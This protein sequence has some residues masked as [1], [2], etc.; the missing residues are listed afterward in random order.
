MQ[1]SSRVSSATKAYED[2]EWQRVADAIAARC[3][4]PRAKRTELHVAGS[5]EGAARALE[6]TREAWHLL[7]GDEPLPLDGIRD[8]S[9]HL[10]RLERQ[11]ALE[12]TALRDVQSTVG[13]ARVL[14]RFLG[15]RK[16]QVP[17][18]HQACSLDPTLDGLEE[19]IKAT[20]EPEGTVSSNASPELRKLR[21]EV[22]NLRGR[23][24]GRLESLIEKRADIL[25]D[26]YYTI[27]EGRY[28]LPVRTDAHERLSGIVHGT[29][30][31]G[32]T[33][34]VEP[35]ELVTQGNRLKMA[36]SQ[37][38]REENRLLAELSD[39]VREHLGALRAAVDALDHADLRGAAARFG[40]DLECSMVELCEARHVR[41][42]RARHPLL[43]LEGS[44]VVPHDLE[45]EAGQALVISGPN[46]GGKTVALKVLGLTALMVRAGLPIPC[47]EGSRCGFF[48]PVLTD[49]GDH[50]S[51][52]ASLSTFSAHITNIAS[53]LR[54]TDAGAL[55]LL[56]EIA[57]STD[58]QEGAA[59]AC[60]IVDTLCKRGSATAVTTHYEPLKAMAARD[61]RMRNAS[62]GFDVQKMQPTFEL[63]L[64][65]PG[66]SSALAVAGRFGIEQTVLEDAR[67]RLPDQAQQF[68]ALVHELESRRR[69]LD[70]AHREV[71]QQRAQAERKQ[72][73]A[74]RRLEKLKMREQEKLG[75]E[76]QKLL[77][78]IRLARS[79]VDEARK[80]VRRDEVDDATVRQARE[81]VDGAAR[82]LGEAEEQTRP[83]P[84]EPEPAPEV[85]PSEIAVGDR[86][87][88]PRL[89]G[90]GEVIE[91]ADK[92]RVR[93]AAGAL[94]MWVDLEGLRKVQARSNGG[95]TG[96]GPGAGASSRAAVAPTQ[97]KGGANAPPGPNPDNTLDVRG[98]RVDEALSLTESFVDRLYGGE[99]PVGY[100]L[101]GIGSG[102]L[103]DAI[104]AR[105]REQSTYVHQTRPGNRD[106]GG[107][108]VTV[109]FVR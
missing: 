60:A 52:A 100:V 38:E 27:R 4:G 32:A 36:E 72:A 47:E 59:L 31:S 25:Q 29:S 95:Q 66:S 28:V 94:K 10:D 57:G 8:V 106:E 69:A 41:L 84:A 45:L 44:D 78:Q 20:I 80:R 14:R 73:D 30:A 11:G 18:L 46:A 40:Q 65:V 89:Q 101:H 88:V 34:F 102:A 7:A 6:E 1:R 108:K 64:D 58:P 83:A 2:L 23:L 50:Q 81:T 75:K 3:R 79:E 55:V 51:I 56:D 98:L 85:S 53:V 9:P 103:R 42:H 61:D 86:V 39:R 70:E 96:T 105:L 5:F 104:R 15:K 97:A 93:V 13:A 74:D 87:W 77:D 71:E 48:D 109:V 62:V 92:G 17:K 107:D 67:C 99:Q 37:M 54:E 63:T 19:E 16:S 33:L 22:A 24:I 76:S 12:A 82:T 91:P 68:E 35:S 26:H 43:A 49:V 90:E 21:T